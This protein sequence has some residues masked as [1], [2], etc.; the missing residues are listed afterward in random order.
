[1]P[2]LKTQ[3]K[4]GRRMARDLLLHK[5]RTVKLWNKHLQDFYSGIG[6][7]WTKAG[8]CVCRPIDFLLALLL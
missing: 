5:Y 7:N 1:M 4:Y 6:K 8:Q 3:S 2:F